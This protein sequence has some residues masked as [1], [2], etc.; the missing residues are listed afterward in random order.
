MTNWK[1]PA[2]FLVVAVAIGLALQVLYWPQL[3]ERMATH[4]DAQG[5]PNGWMDRA[6]AAALSVGLLLFLP[7]FFIGIS[8]AIRWL[9]TSTINLPHREYWLSAERRDD[10]LRW[11]TVWMMWFSVAITIFLVAINHLTFIANRDARPLSAVWFWGLLGAFLLTTAALV[12]LMYRRF[13][14]PR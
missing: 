9:P 8:V 10:T 13:G 7:L 5:N 12:V 14:S 2:A 4:F 1:V 3:P 6:A 11:M